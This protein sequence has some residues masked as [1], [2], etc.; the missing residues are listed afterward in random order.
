MTISIIIPT[1]NEAENIEK[2]VLH[3]QKF[4]GDNLLEIIVA[5]GG[6]TD[7]TCSIARQLGAKIVGSVRGRAQQ[8]NAGAAA[9]AGEVLYFVHA[10][11]L[12]PDDFLLFLNKALAEN[13]AL[14][15]FRFRFDSP[16][17]IL[18]INA[19]FTRFDKIWCRGGDQTLF[20]RQS[21]FETL[22][23]YRSD[24]LIMEEYEFIERA[25]Q[26]YAFKIM[27]ADVMVS[28]RKY[29]TNSWLRV[30]IANLT[31]F[32]MYRM[33]VSQARLVGTYQRMLDYR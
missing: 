19:Y 7:A 31:V 8:M 6:S 4:G 30:Q 13:Y 20:V 22:G 14:G 28:A 18:K 5:D 24:F 29:E 3:L 32:R 23:G 15:C 1:L 26:Q 33:G 27:P 11:T 9:A 10:D 25:R 16:R 12:P 2:L 17:W 21:V